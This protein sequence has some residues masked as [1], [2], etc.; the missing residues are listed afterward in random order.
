MLKAATSAL[1]GDLAAA[2]NLQRIWYQVNL[3]SAKWF[4]IGRQP[5]SG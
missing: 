1:A 4:V 3:H 5:Q 2:P